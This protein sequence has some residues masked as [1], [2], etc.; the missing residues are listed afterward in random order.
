M[1]QLTYSANGWER[2][3]VL[4]AGDPLNTNRV[5]VLIDLG[6]L[7]RHYRIYGIQRGVVHRSRSTAWTTNK[8]VS[9]MQNEIAIDKLTEIT[10]LANPCAHSRAG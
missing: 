5:Y 10:H 6:R 4:A 3:L 9:N 1:Y 2:L 8:K 7:H